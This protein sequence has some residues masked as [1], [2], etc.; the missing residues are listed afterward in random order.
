MGAK[1]PK[2]PSCPQFALGLGPALCA[3]HLC[4]SQCREGS[5]A[6]AATACIYQEHTGWLPSPQ[7]RGP[8]LGVTLLSELR[9]LFSPFM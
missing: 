8:I 2:S 3:W 9:G 4:K 6:L 7:A 5:P 1:D